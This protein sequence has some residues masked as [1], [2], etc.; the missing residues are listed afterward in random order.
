MTRPHF[1]AALL[2]AGISAPVA[3]SSSQSTP[4]LPP[5]AA[6]AAAAAAAPGARA[7]TLELSIADAVTL[8]L[9][10]GEE[11]RIA[12]AQVQVA[13]AQA[14][15][16]RASAL[17]QLRVNGTYTHV[18][19]N[20]RAQA[21]GSI[22]N[23][24]NTYNTNLNISQTLFQ[25]GREISAIRAARRVREA[26]RL[27]ATETRA[28]VA[29]DVQRAYLQVLFARRMVEISSSGLRLADE[30]LRQVEQ[31]QNAGRAARYD[32]LRARVE[33]ANYEPTVIQATSD[34]DLA[35][36]ELKRLANVPADRPVRLTSSIDTTTVNALLAAARDSSLEPVERPSL[37]AARLTAE[38]RHLGV[39]V[40]RADMLPTIS[41]FFQTGYQAFPPSGFPTRW[42]EVAVV[43]CAP[44]APAGCRPTTQQNGGW[45]SDRSVGVQVSWP[46]FDGLR[47]KGNMD[48]ARA[49]ARLADLALQQEREAVS[50][51]VA[52]A[53]ADLARA[54]SLFEARRQNAGEADEAFRLAS[55]RFSRG[56][57]TQL[58]TSDAQLALLTAQT[59]EARAFYDLYLATA[60]LARALGRPVPLPTRGPAATRISFETKTP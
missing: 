43:P 8:A 46:L 31:F 36:I 21:V 49:Q 55:L 52:R 29:L 3:V 15:V 1:L 41:V 5:V 9:R 54:R 34:F 26:A 53:R 6:P 30:R 16:A 25:G 33:R 28:Q 39:S 37:R 51:E 38:A 10:S 57:G 7:D 44:D 11:A 48:L 22:F 17:P 60:E 47:T 42:G 40:A 19:E 23:Q 45:F 27:D 12:A 14:T 20:A 24:P 18:I 13:E 4:P 35:L 56:L 59:N 32:V 58:E 2:A 50:V